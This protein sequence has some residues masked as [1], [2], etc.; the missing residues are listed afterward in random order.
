MEIILE[1]RDLFDKWGFGDGDML[2]DLLEDHGIDPYI[3]EKRH[4]KTYARIQWSLEARL[5]MRLVELY[6]LPVL[7]VQLSPRFFDSH[8]NPVRV[9]EWAGRFGDHIP[10]ELR[11]IKVSISD[12]FVLHAAGV[13]QDEIKA[14][15]R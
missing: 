1:A 6:L 7:P 8:H 9:N 4:D 5:L 11:D 14:A 3:G 2:A 12:E 10:A 15:S 13:L